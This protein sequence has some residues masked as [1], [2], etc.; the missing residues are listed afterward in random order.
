MPPL[1]VPAPVGHRNAFYG[2]EQ[3]RVPGGVVIDL[4]AQASTG[5]ASGTRVESGLK[6][7]RS[8]LAGECFTSSGGKLTFRSRRE[9]AGAMMKLA[10]I[11]RAVHIARN[12]STVTINTSPPHARSQDWQ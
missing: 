1:S 6:A 2:S 7:A 10:T 5:S 12:L 9:S 4:I 3:R 11:E 8:A